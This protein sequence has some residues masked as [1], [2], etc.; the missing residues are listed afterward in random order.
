[1]TVTGSFDD[2]NRMRDLEKSDRLD[3]VEK[4]LDKIEKRFK[5]VRVVLNNLANAQT[6]LAGAL[7]R[8]QVRAK[9][10]EMDH[11]DNHPDIGNTEEDKEKNW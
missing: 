6:E 3:L 2:I 7:H 9:R 1:M 8:T 10:K 11:N 5:T 4:R